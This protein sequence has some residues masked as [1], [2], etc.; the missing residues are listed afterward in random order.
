MSTTLEEASVEKK[1]P[2]L[3]LSK[4]WRMA[5][6]AF[7]GLV[8]LSLIRVITGADDLT[9]A[10]TINA[11]VML[12][13]PIGLAGLGGLWSERAGVVNIGLEGMMIL[14]SFGAGWI[15]WQHGAWAG[16]LMAIAF[17]VLG[18]L[19]H[20]LA[21]VTF[22][23][24][25]VVSGVAINIL[26]LGATQ[27][28]AGELLADSP[29]G[30]ESQSPPNSGLPKP[31]VPGLSGLL[32]PVEEHHWFLISDIAG[33][34]RGLL[35]NV[36]LLTIV[37]VLL[38][39]ATYLILWQTPFGLRLRSV[40][41]DPHAA[42]SLGVKVRLYKYYAV[43]ISGGLAGLAGGFLAIVASNLYREGQTG[44]RGYIGLAAMIFGNWRPGGL[45]MGAGLFGY[46]DAMQ[47]RNAA[48]VHALLLVVFALL[49]VVTAL[50][51]YR[52]RWITAGVGVV[53]A[54][55]SLLWYLSSDELPGPIT[56]MT[57]YV[58]TLL[59]LALAAQHLRP[60]KASG[61]V[62]RPEGK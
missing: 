40:G 16:V 57:P 59:V 42:E 36:S 50:N 19:V 11:A 8:V 13:V 47:L 6:Y 29:G 25:H 33:I 21:T 53:F 31:S 5:L 3:G 35:T 41:E 1:A 58:T 61:E 15:G 27:Y 28:L 32:E 26:G 12:A 20:A 4:P 60:P 62:Y 22:G 49:V 48:A 24:D 51:I 56:A 34:L 7:A 55:L 44:G 52:R 10:G 18:G 46:T 38:V 30:G 23:V 14:G 2:L 39:L 9:S 54:V 37:A 17:G 45:M 43:A